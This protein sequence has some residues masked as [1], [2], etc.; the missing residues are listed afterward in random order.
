M[1]LRATNKFIY[2]K[3]FCVQESFIFVKCLGNVLTCNKKS[4]TSTVIAYKNLLYFFPMFRKCVC[5]Q[6]KS[7]K[8]LGED[9]RLLQ[10]SVMEFLKHIILSHLFASCYIFLLSSCSEV[11]VMKSKSH[12]LNL[13]G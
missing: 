1:C 12:V 11:S 2:F 6:P 4:Y 7:Q 9:C 13:N 5:V 8:F 10:V 3:C